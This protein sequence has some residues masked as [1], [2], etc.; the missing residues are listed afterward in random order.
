LGRMGLP[1]GRGTNLHVQRV[2]VVTCKYQGPHERKAT[3]HFIKRRSDQEVAFGDP[4]IRLARRMHSTG[5]YCHALPRSPT[6]YSQHWG[7]PMMRAWRTERNE[8]R[9]RQ[10]G[11]NSTAVV[12][13]YGCRAATAG[14][15][16]RGRMLQGCTAHAPLSLIQRQDRHVPAR[17]Q[18]GLRKAAQ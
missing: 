17:R 1:L 7:L 16:R 13:S 4:V 11:P 6:Y 3:Q 14:P 15:I 9:W 18:L 8:T 5:G 12:R 10:A 2:L